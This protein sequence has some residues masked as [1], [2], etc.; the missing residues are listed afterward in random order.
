MYLLLLLSC[1]QKTPPPPDAPDPASSL[2]PRLQATLLPTPS[3]PTLSPPSIASTL[4]SSCS[5]DLKQTPQD[6][7]AKRSANGWVLLHDSERVWLTDPKGRL[8]LLN[9]NT[10]DFLS[11]GSD[12]WTVSGGNPRVVTHLHE[13]EV[14]GTIALPLPDFLALGVFAQQ[15]GLFGFQDTWFGAGI[16]NATTILWIADDTGLPLGHLTYTN[17]RKFQRD[18]LCA[19][20]S[21]V[22]V[23]EKEGGDH[24]VEG[25]RIGKDG[26]AEE[27]FLSPTSGWGVQTVIIGEA[28]YAL[29]I[30]DTSLFVAQWEKGSW[31]GVGRMEGVAAVSAAAEEDHLLIAWAPSAGTWRVARLGP[32]GLE[33]AREIPETTSKDRV[34]LQ[35]TTSGLNLAVEHY[36]PLDHWVGGGR[37]SEDGSPPPPEHAVWTLSVQLASFV[38]E[39]SLVYSKPYSAEGYDEGFPFVRPLLREKGAAWIVQHE[40]SKAVLLEAGG[41]GK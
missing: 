30:E 37:P 22:F 35:P 21:C 31:S 36:T 14:V 33:H 4:L 19:A 24:R 29:F 7:W 12:R 32:K 6:G 41:C 23:G 3:Y 40:G 10:T 17:Y 5:P 13:T 25:W 38:A 28:L 2:G 20:E 8:L 26:T 18:G 27:I 15:K 1:A 16:S 34:L 9:Q 11:A 39:S